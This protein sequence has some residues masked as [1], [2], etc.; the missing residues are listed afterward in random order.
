MNPL[1]P[2]KD[3][4]G[5]KSFFGKHLVEWFK[6]GNKAGRHTRNWQF[7]K[8]KAKQIERRRKKNKIARKSRRINRLVAQGKNKRVAI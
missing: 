1:N 5:N 6:T 3:D 2:F 7:D 4:G 8:M